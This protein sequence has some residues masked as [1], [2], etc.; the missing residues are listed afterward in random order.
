MDRAPLEPTP[1]NRALWQAAERAAR[2]LGIELGEGTSGGASD[3]STTSQIVAT[4]DGL[5]AVGDGAHAR[6]EHVVVDH[7]PERAA[8]LARLM[9]EPLSST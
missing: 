2:E 3:G 5:G 4:L 7:M 9:M 8:L 6:H 1:G